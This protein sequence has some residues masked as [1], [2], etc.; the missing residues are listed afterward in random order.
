MPASFLPSG[1]IWFHLFIPL[2][3]HTGNLSFATILWPDASNELFSLLPFFINDRYGTCDKFKHIWEKLQA[4]KDHGWIWRKQR[5]Y[6]KRL[7]VKQG[8]DRKVFVAVTDI[9]YKCLCF[10]KMQTIKYL[11]YSL[12]QALGMFVPRLHH[13]V[14]AV[15]WAFA[16]TIARHVFNWFVY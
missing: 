15:Y 2:S 12:L 13:L 8:S 6:M 16:L 11:F 5:C 1:S 9:Q 10:I 4:R 7:A 14:N 3:I